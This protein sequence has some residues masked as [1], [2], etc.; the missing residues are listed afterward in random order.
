[1]L[2]VHH[3]R[4]A[5]GRQ[6]GIAGVWELPAP[7]PP[8]ARST[9]PP[10]GS[11]CPGTCQSH[12]LVYRGARPPSAAEPPG[13]S[14][15]CASRC[16]PPCPCCSQTRRTGTHH[17]RVPVRGFFLACVPGPKSRFMA[18]TSICHFQK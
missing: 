9:P 2:A 4:P 16:P 17:P 7:P 18:Q 12:P 10:H 5:G 15:A 11:D 13:T 14:T 6:G 8:P 1:V 3:G